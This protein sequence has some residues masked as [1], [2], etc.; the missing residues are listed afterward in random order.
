M[1]QLQLLS[2]FSTRRK[3]KKEKGKA[4]PFKDNHFHLHHIAFRP[5]N[6]PNCKGGWKISF[7]LRRSESS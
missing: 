6:T 3:E 4:F 2:P 7:G 1:L 5:M